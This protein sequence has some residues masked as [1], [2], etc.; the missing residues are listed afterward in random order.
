M[1]KAI[2]IYPEDCIGCKACQVACKQWNQLPAEATTN[3][4]SY[5]NPPS[6]SPSTYTR[7]LFQEKKTAQGLQWLFRKEQCLHC[8]Q[9]TCMIVCPAPGAI[10]RTKE[11]AVVFHPEKCIG[12]RHCVN[13]CPFQIPRFDHKTGKAT[14]C[15]LCHD[16]LEKGQEPF[17][18]HI[19]PTGSLRFG[20]RHLLLKEA[21]ERGYQFIYGDKELAGTHVMLALPSDPSHYGLPKE[22][23]VPIALWLWKYLAKIL[24]GSGALI[25]IMGI[26]IHAISTIKSR[27]QEM[28]KGEKP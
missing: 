23:K 14:K 10:V 26:F 2:M 6:L 22:P 19:C 27:Q 13:L 18:V 1:S 4:G 20:D 9:A 17:C 8:S 16:R 11:G 15:H 12:C 24:L 21:Q 5:E 3:M 25:A 28:G 7:I